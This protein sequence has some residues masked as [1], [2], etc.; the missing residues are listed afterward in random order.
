MGKKQV[1]EVVYKVQYVPLELKLIQLDK[2]GA[3]SEP[4]YT[5]YKN[6]R[7]HYVEF[8][9]QV[10]IPNFGEEFLKYETSESSY[11]S[12]LD[13]YSFQFKNDIRFIFDQKDT[14]LCDEFIFERNFGISPNASFVIGTS[15]TKK[16]SQISVLVNDRVLS[17]RK[18]IFDF[19]NKDI[20]KL[21][22][23]KKYNKW[24]K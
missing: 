12:R 18:V 3:M 10:S 15:I 21:P 19:S 14:V 8:L 16:Y 20:K 2:K 7:K 6:D 4:L 17:D 13:Y 9:L 5:Q 22:S 23:L 11:E 24:K 1:G